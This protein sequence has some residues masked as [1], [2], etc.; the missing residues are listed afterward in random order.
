MTHADG[1]LWRVAARVRYL[2]ITL[3]EPPMSMNINGTR[4]H[5]MLILFTMVLFGIGRV[6]ASDV[7]QQQV[8]EPV[9]LLNDAAAEM[10]SPSVSEV[11]LEQVRV[12]SRKQA[13]EAAY[14]L[15]IVAVNREDLAS[16]QVLIEEAL[17]IQPSNPNY[18]LA[19][20]R[21]ATIT[22]EYNTA[23]QYQLKTLE[24]AQSMLGPDDLR[25]AALMDELSTIY[26]A[27]SRYQEAE[28]LLRQGL[29]FREQALGETHPSVAGS[30]NNL[31][32][33]AMKDRRFDEAEKL[34]KR[35]L[36]ILKTSSDTSSDTAH[37]DAAI[38]MHNLG[39]FYTSQKRF[40]EAEDLYRQALTIWVVTPAK[41]RLQLA[42]YLNE[43]GNFYQSQNRLDEA[44]PQ[45]DLVITLLSDEFGQDHPYI[46]VARTGLEALKD[47]R[48]KRSEVSNFSQRLFDEL[49][50]QIS[51]YSQ[52][53]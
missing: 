30:L 13:A 44:R 12:N 16:A 32:G 10:P 31:A 50:A 18:L 17:Q 1:I 6:S 26:I 49:Q 46:S 19:A 52:V 11:F 28:A 34:L 36:H 37:P 3:G 43:L 27:Q 21:V 14:N 22:G 20:A 40:S 45:F 51:E 2:K 33:F 53:N 9:S 35:T 29:E 15:A 8:A 23:E 39:D 7:F 4:S 42:V 48:E 41:F 25:I 24:V 5:F 47:A 38:A